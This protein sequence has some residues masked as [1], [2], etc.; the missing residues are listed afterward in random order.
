MLLP[1]SSSRFYHLTNIGWGVQIIKFLIIV[2]PKPLL[3][4]S[5]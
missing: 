4:R 3:P 2:F 1:N 5:S